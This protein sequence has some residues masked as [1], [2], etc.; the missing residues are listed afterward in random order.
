[1][2]IYYRISDNSNTGNRIT[3]KTT[4]FKLFINEFGNENLLIIGD[5]IN[6]E[7]YDLIKKYNHEKT[8]L[9]NCGSFRYILDKAL[10]LPDDEVILFQEDDYIYQ[11]NCLNLIYEGLEMAD[12]I[13]LYDCPDKY[14]PTSKGGNLQIGENVGE[15]TRVFTTYSSHWKFTNST[16]MTFASKVKTLKQDYD[17]WLKYTNHHGDPSDYPAFCELSNKGKKIATSIPG[18]CTHNEVFYLTPLVD[19]CNIIEGK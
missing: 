16:T 10:Q 17:I 2:H 19:W 15:L 5:N 6:S 3:D 12:Y 14:L 18:R 8:N 7:T 11:S 1:M 9:G 4:C 13:S